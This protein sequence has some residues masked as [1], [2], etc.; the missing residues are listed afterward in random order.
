MIPG[1]IDAENMIPKHI[2]DFESSDS[3]VEI[4]NNAQIGG[5]LSRAPFGKED[6]LDGKNMQ[7]IN[8]EDFEGSL[9]GSLPGLDAIFDQNQIEETRL[10]TDVDYG[11]HDFNEDDYQERLDKLSLMDRDRYLELLKLKHKYSNMKADL[12]RADQ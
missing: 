4:A 6:D 8:E 9:N 12:V 10:E 1:W 11:L 3:E 2:K 5:R 7:T